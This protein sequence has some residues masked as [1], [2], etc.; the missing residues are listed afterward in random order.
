[1][2]K[3]INNHILFLLNILQIYHERTI[4][5]INMLKVYTEF[6]LT[7]TQHPIKIPI[8]PLISK[9]VLNNSTY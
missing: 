6:H 4:I 2:Q 9:C 1:M 8:I 5:L 7:L 3:T